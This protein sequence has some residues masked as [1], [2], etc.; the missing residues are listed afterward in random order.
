MKFAAA[1]ALSLLSPAS[2]FVGP[3][4]PAHESS[5]TCLS[6]TSS[7]RDALINV[8]RGSGFVLGTVLGFPTASKAGTANPFFLEEVNFEPS[9]MARNDKIDINGAFVVS[10]MCHCTMIAILFQLY[11]S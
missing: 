4:F 9:Q 2:A 8:V 11:I 7:R 1:V 5:N 3:I 6:A 10:V